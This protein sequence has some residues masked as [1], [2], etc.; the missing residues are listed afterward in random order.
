MKKLAR[1]FQIIILAFVL[2][3]GKISAVA[4]EKQ[5]KFIF[6]PYRAEAFDYN[7]YDFDYFEKNKYAVLLALDAASAGFLTSDDIEEIV[8]NANV[9]VGGND[10]M[11]VVGYIVDSRIK[12][13]FYIPSNVFPQLCMA[14][15]FEAYEPRLNQEQASSVAKERIQSAVGGCEQI[16]SDDMV[17]ML[18]LMKEVFN[19]ND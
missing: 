10:L 14:N 5:T 19:D 6:P 8:H 16:S 11:I 2:V 1:R 9:Y 18:D 3:C 15:Y 7:P 17:T 13:I 4:E 12:I